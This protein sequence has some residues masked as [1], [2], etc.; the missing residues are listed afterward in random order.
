[1][2]ANQP[3]IAVVTA[4]GTR[5]PIDEVR[6]IANA[7]TGA[8]PCAIAEHLLQWG[9]QVHYMHGLGAKLPEIQDDR[10]V[11]HPIGTADSAARE[12]ARLCRTHQP[13]L[14]VCAMAVADYAP[15][16]AEGKLS[17]HLAQPGQPLLLA[18]YP[19]PK[20]IDVVKVAAPHTFLLGFKLLAGADE[21]AQFAAAVQLAARSK[22]DL[23]LTND[24]RRYA[25]G[26]SEGVLVAPDGSVVARLG[27]GTGADGRSQF[28]KEIVNCVV[29]RLNQQ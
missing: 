6:Y 9:W 2:T 19:T 27:G 12:L 22:A 13:Q 21:A 5:E 15:R 16:P 8:L 4:G 26:V 1:M 17:S 14:T 10:L 29:E 11:L 25:S 18:L 24:M 3:R 20:T 28:A 23:V 7:A